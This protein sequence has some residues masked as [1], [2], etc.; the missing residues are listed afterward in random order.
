MVSFFW[1]NSLKIGSI[2]Q[3]LFYI[4][5]FRDLE[6]SV[7]FKFYLI[8]MFTMFLAVLG[9]VAAINLLYNNGF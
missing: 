5:C 3:T 9:N 1:L 8:L 4:N 2:L 6:K 7:V